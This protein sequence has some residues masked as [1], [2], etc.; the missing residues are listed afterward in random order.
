MCCI[1]LVPQEEMVPVLS[2]VWFCSCFFF[3]FKYEDVEM[4]PG[5][6]SAKPRLFFALLILLMLL[7]VL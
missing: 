4:F 7:F 1:K 3:F 5:V 6:N 2:V